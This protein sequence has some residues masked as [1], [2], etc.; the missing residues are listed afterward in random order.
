MGFKNENEIVDVHIDWITQCSIIINNYDHGIM[1]AEIVELK[2]I[3]PKISIRALAQ[4]EKR[5]LLEPRVVSN[6]SANFEE[7]L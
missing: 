1:G 6:S 5:A 7:I 4:R 3:E 2:K